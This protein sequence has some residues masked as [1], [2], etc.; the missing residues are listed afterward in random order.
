MIGARGQGAMQ[1]GNSKYLHSVIF[2]DARDAVPRLAFLK[3][4]PRHFASGQALCGRPLK[5]IL[6]MLR[7]NLAA[8]GESE[9]EFW[10]MKKMNSPVWFGGLPPHALFARFVVLQTSI[11]RSAARL[12]AAPMLLHLLDQLDVASHHVIL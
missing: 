9:H 2:D 7:K 5:F 11:S 6:A 8:E 4:P 10:Q 12:A 3:V 1:Q